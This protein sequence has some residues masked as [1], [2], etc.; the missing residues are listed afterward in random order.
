MRRAALRSFRTRLEYNPEDDAS[1]REPL[2]SGKP[3]VASAPKEA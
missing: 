2:F 1:V 3:A